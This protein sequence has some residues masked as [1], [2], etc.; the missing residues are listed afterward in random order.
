MHD[1]PPLIVT[2]QLDDESQRFFDGLRQRY[3]PPERNFL[4]A[5]LTLFHHLP[6]DESQVVEHLKGWG[7]ETPPLV[8]EVAEVKSIGK[9]V[10]YKIDCPPLIQLHTVMRKTWDQ[11]LQPQ[12][13][14]KLWPHV[15]VQNK[16]TPQTA[17]DT[18]MELQRSFAP[19][20]AAG[21]GFGL[22]RYE[23]GPWT[24]LEA[25]RFEAR[26]HEGH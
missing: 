14:Q 19:F 6:P 21:T 15:T 9:G 1:A 22:W 17:K 26:R 8:L 12:D 18:L 4:S 20:T 2:L 7:T 11:W 25:F 16:V 24:F 13:K 10:A 5:H 23:G 3:F